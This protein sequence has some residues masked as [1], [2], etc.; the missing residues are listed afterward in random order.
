MLGA[1]GERGD[2]FV[3]KQYGDSI[4]WIQLDRSNPAEL[5]HPSQA[6][7]AD[8]KKGEDQLAGRDTCSSSIMD[9]GSNRK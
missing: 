2:K 6:S 3:L 1:R 7:T 4:S 9:S 5:Y 8:T